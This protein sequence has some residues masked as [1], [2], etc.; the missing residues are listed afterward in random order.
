MFQAKLQKELLGQ[1]SVHAGH[2]AESVESRGKGRP[3]DI[4]WQDT[5]ERITRYRA[6]SLFTSAIPGA[7]SSLP[8]APLLPGDYCCYNWDIT[9]I[10]YSDSL[11]SSQNTPRYSLMWV[12]LKPE[13]FSCLTQAGLE[14]LTRYFSAVGF[15]LHSSSTLCLQQLE[16][17]GYR[18]F[19]RDQKAANI[20]PPQQ[21]L[22]KK[23]RK[24]K[25]KL[26]SRTG[27]SG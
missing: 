27:F 13:Q 10:N 17:Q 4:P 22:K 1:L 12:E 9:L 23:K 2:K 21:R 16:I 25:M 19:L 18:E 6:Y 5:A 24:R 3:G 8:A 15:C 11:T 7:H 20:T 26:G 14:A